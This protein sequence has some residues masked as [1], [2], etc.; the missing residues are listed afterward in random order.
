MDST[1]GILIILGTAKAGTSALAAWLGARE[2]IAPGRIKEPRF[3]S[4]LDAREWTG[5]GAEEFRATLLADEGAWLAN[6]E[7]R[8]GAAWALDAST[9]YLWCPASPDRIAA[10]AERV[11]IRLICITRDP[12]DRAISQ[13]RHTLRDGADETL[14]AALDA[15]ESRIAQG[16]QPLYWHVRRSRIA[17]DLSVYAERF[18]DRLLVVD[19]AELSDPDALLARVARFLC[20]P[21]RPLEAEEGHN[22]SVLPRN[23]LVKAAFA[24]P[25]LKSAARA[26]LPRALRH[27]IY[28]ASHSAQA[29]PIPIR[30]EE[31][32]RLRDLLADEIA[33]CIRSPLI[34]TSGWRSAIPE[35][36]R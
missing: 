4:D 12:V 8:P 36:A 28:Q 16:W 3:L 24:S 19:Y 30:P 7:H 27:R 1:R 6:F 15:E 34:D 31:I 2:D 26:L 33:A 13:Y 18:G 35:P 20:L 14:H 11:P 23:R 22:R 29:A 5:P 21:E 9:D 17:E 25:A 10:L 32:A